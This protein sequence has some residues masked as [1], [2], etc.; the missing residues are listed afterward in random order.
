MSFQTYGESPYQVPPTI[1]YSFHDH[2]PVQQLFSS[3]NAEVP[4]SPHHGH[5]GGGGGVHE[6]SGT[7]VPYGHPTLYT[8]PQPPSISQFPH[9]PH[10]H[11]ASSSL[12][13]T[14]GS[15]TLAQYYHAAPRH[16]QQQQQH[17]YSNHHYSPNQQQPH[18]HQNYHQ[19]P[20]SP[21]QQQQ[22][23][24][25]FSTPFVLAGQP[26]GQ[27][28]SVRKRG[29]ELT[30]IEA[31]DHELERIEEA[32]LEHEM[33]LRAQYERY[34]E[35]QYQ[36]QQRQQQIQDQHQHQHQ[37]QHQHQQHYRRLPLAQEQQQQQQHSQPPFHH[38]STYASSFQGMLPSFA[39][40]G[41][42]LVASV[43]ATATAISA[44]PAMNIMTHQQQQQQQQQPIATAVVAPTTTTPTHHD[45]RSTQGIP[46]GSGSTVTNQEFAPQPQLPAAAAIAATTT[47]TPTPT[48]S[49]SPSTG[50]TAITV[51]G[52]AAVTPPALL[53]SQIQ[54]Q[55]PPQQQTQAAPTQ[56]YDLLLPSMLTDHKSP[57]PAPLVPTMA[58]TAA[59]AAAA[60]SPGSVVPQQQKQQQQRLSFDESS[61][62]PSLPPSEKHGV[63]HSPPQPQLL[64]P[65]PH[66]P[67]PQ[68]QGQPQPQSQLQRQGQQKQTDPLQPPLPRVF[69][70]KF[71]KWSS[72][73]YYESEKDEADDD[74]T[75]MD[76]DGTQP[77]TAAK[78]SSQT[79]PS[80]PSSKSTTTKEADSAEATPTPAGQLEGSAASATAAAAA[81]KKGTVRRS[82]APKAMHRTA[83]LFYY[84]STVRGKWPHRYPN[85]QQQ[86]LV[87]LEQQQQQ[88]RRQQKQLQQLQQQQ[89]YQQQQHELLLSSY[90]AQA[91]VVAYQKSEQLQKESCLHDLGLYW[92][93]TG[94]QNLR[95]DGNSWDP[96]LEVVSWE[97][98][99]E[100]DRQTIIPTHEHELLK[101]PYPNE[102]DRL[103][104]VYY[105]NEHM[106]PPILH[107]VMIEKARRTLNLMYSRLLL[108]TLFGIAGKFDA[109]RKERE[110]TNTNATVASSMAVGLKHDG[111]TQYFNRAHGLLRLMESTYMVYST[112]LVQIKILLYFSFPNATMSDVIPTIDRDIIFLGMHEDCSKWIAHPM[113][114]SYRL[115]TFWVGFLMDSVQMVMKG[116]LSSIGDVFIKTE[117]PTVTDLDHDD[118][119]WT[120]RFVVHEV[121]LW[122]IGRQCYEV[123]EKSL[124][125]LEVLASAIEDEREWMLIMSNATTTATEG[126]KGNNNNNNNAMPGLITASSRQESVSP[127]PTTTTTTTT[128]QT[129]SAN[130]TTGPASRLRTAAAI[131]Q[132]KA[133]FWQTALDREASEIRLMVLLEKWREELPSQLVADL[134]ADEI[135]GSSGSSGSS[136][137]SSLPRPPTAVSANATEAAVAESGRAENGIARSQ[138]PSLQDTSQPPQL[139]ETSP[140]SSCSQPS[141]DVN[142]E[143]EMRKR[144]QHAV[145]G[146]AIALEVVQS[147]LKIM[148]WYHY[149]LAVGPALDD[150]VRAVEKDGQEER[151]SNSDWSQAKLHGGGMDSTS[152]KCDYLRILELYQSRIQQTVREADR[153]VMLGKVLLQHYPERTAICCLG[154][155]LDWALRIYHRVGLYGFEPLVASME[156]RAKAPPT[157]AHQQQSQQQQQQRMDMDE[158][159]GTNTPSQPPPPPMRSSPFGPN[160]TKR[161]GASAELKARCRAQALRVWPLLKQY[162]NLGYQYYWSWHLAEH[163][164]LVQERAAE[165]DAMIQQVAAVQRKLIELQQLQRRS[166]AT[167]TTTAAAAAIIPTTVA[168][169]VPSQSWVGVGTGTV[170]NI[171]GDGDRLDVEVVDEKRK[172]HNIETLRR[173]IDHSRQVLQHQH[174]HQPQQHEMLSSDHHASVLASMG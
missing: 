82:T 128:D 131:T 142:N 2:S 55:T 122:R 98:A 21:P 43:P 52:A 71:P 9:H 84:P 125:E 44:A 74:G 147:L 144:A 149:I 104:H 10:S 58:T 132:D 157:A 139:Q 130:T 174:Q 31:L 54:Q 154:K 165:Q 65:A 137:S 95:P 5:G 25:Q 42:A 117:L 37:Y 47:P 152:T 150:L 75:S 11:T 15:G 170:D 88:H 151:Q 16:Q 118:Y 24:Q 163:D 172:V 7:G 36:L 17:Y 29:R 105:E 155:G 120:R 70:P 113:V 145:N 162:R 134:E 13:A 64:H 129:S 168:A 133:R 77:Y 59:A 35:E 106:L 69:I 119:F 90:P 4:A 86:E 89:Y 166:Q 20:L 33:A 114:R 116:N 103:I 115:W 34:M 110:G 60:M 135:V 112:R 61:G 26:A 67:T 153:L 78:H 87:T 38:Q 6:G 53:Q 1:A 72:S 51:I 107:R 140:L 143:S 62:K 100:Q 28:D 80:G 171:G 3:P 50:A 46:I 169:T 39:T 99:R 30:Q 124:D 41:S 22:Q 158:T 92:P 57:S 97:Q 12:Q 159:M 121:K 56:S 63:V 8:S 96:Q 76:K 18:Y 161:R 73:S 146:R 148:I 66:A 79:A 85:Y 126:E 81:A 45:L 91:T 48:T 111:F 94:A 27:M 19:V 108:N 138:Q 123:F 109:I 40:A 14:G 32:Q 68:D 164:S 101:L 93:G 160:T 156:A 136:S 23:Q 102:V 127:M 173:R 83:P 49:S 167:A 141:V